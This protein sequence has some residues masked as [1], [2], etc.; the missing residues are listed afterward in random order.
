MGKIETENYYSRIDQLIRMEATGAPADLA[1]RLEIHQ[2]T[3]FRILDRMKA[4]GCPI[5]YDRK[6]KTYY[7]AEPGRFEIAHEFKPLDN[8]QMKRLSGGMKTFF[9]FFCPLAKNASEGQY[10]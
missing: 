6:K 7:Y 9:D 10:I 1:G 3:L 2:S 4:F 5:K 8:E